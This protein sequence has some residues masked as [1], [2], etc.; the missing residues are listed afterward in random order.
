M[1]IGRG[2]M[3][4]VLIKTITNFLI[5]HVGMVLYIIYS[6]QPFDSFQTIGMGYLNKDMF[7]PMGLWGGVFI[8]AHMG[9][10]TLV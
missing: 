10:K 8:F 6:F 7:R 9:Y 5:I 1:K 4:Y 3:F 2:V